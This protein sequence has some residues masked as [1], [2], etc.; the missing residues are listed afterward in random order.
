ML[1]NRA[2]FDHFWYFLSFRIFFSSCLI[3]GRQLPGEMRYQGRNVDTGKLGM[4]NS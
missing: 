2:N 1:I 3:E 4:T